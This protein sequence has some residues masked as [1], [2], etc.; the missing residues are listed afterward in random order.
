MQDFKMKYVVKWDRFIVFK[1]FH[2]WLLHYFAAQYSSYSSQQKKQ[3]WPITQYFV[4]FNDKLN[5][6]KGFL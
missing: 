3:L 2:P 6:M 5:C 4:L 1:E